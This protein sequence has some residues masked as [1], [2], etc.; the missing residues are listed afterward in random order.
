MAKFRL[1]PPLLPRNGRVLKALGIERISTDNQDAASLEDQKALREG[2]V[3]DR[4]D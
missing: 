4:I 1:D 3:A 2:W